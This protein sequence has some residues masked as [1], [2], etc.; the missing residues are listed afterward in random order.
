MEDR[1][2]QRAVKEEQRWTKKVWG[3]DR[4]NPRIWKTLLNGHLRGFWHAAYG[5]NIT[6][7]KMK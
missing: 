1:L 7:R 2:W 4:Q 3:H 6:C 5:A